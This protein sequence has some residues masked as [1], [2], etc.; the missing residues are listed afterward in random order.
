MRHRRAAGAQTPPRQLLPGLTLRAPAPGRARSG[1][2][3]LRVL[4]P[5]GLY[6]AGGRTGEDAWDAGHIQEPGLRS[7]QNARRR[8]GCLPFPALGRRSLPLPVAGRTLGEGPRRGAGDKCR[9]GAAWTQLLRDL[10]ARG[11]SGA[12]L[13]VSDAHKG[14]TSAIG[15]V[16]PGCAWQRCRTHFMR[17]VLSRVPRSAQPFVATLVR[18]VFA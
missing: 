18:T 5:R 12:R 13:G 4:R 7:C 8:G 16:L 15:A 11:L 17:N 10:V 1:G 9:Y 14:L 6:A 3:H 2:R